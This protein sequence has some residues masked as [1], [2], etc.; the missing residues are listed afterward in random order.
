MSVSVRRCAASALFLCA[1][2]ALSGCAERKA[3][4]FPWHSA[5][6]V[7]PRPPERAVVARAEEETPDLRPLIPP[8]S[9]LITL[10]NAPPR[11]RS[12]SSGAD[13]DPNG[14]VEAPLIVPQLSAE[15][16]ATVQQQT[17][18]NLSI[19]EKNLERARGRALSAPQSDLA[20]K[21]RSFSGQAR[22]AARAGD[23]VRARN[24]AQ[25]AQLLSEEL[26]GSF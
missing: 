24:L 12:A 13:A 23:W 11:P 4:A 3:R 16:S 2:I 9:H 1:V 21:V 25:K 20:D 6:I 26:I 18:K 22:E 7:R 10:R 5:S 17:A 14:R 15:E 8:P 19:A